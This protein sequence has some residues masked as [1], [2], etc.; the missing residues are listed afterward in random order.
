MITDRGARTFAAGLR[1]NSTLKELDIVNNHGIHTAGWRFIFAAFL[2]SMCRFEKIRLEYTAYEF[3]TV[4]LAN[5]LLQ[6]SATLKSLCLDGNSHDDYA[7]FFH[8]LT[9]PNSVL[10]E[11][12]LG[13]YFIDDAAIAGIAN[14][15]SDNSRLKALSLRQ[16]YSPQINPVR[17]LLAFS[18][19]LQN[20]TSALEML[21]LSGNT[22][23]DQTFVSFA[24]ALTSN[25]RLR[26]LVIGAG[27][28]T[29]YNAFKISGGYTAFCRLLC[30]KLS[31]MD[32]YQ[33]NHV[34]EKLI[35]LWDP[36]WDPHNSDE[37]MYLLKINKGNSESQ[38]ARLKIIET[39]FSGPVIYMQ[40]FIDMDLSTRPHAIAWMVR[41]K[42]GYQL[43]RAMP[44][45]LEKFE[46]GGN[47]M[48]RKRP[49]DG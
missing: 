36:W 43:L 45:L 34:L 30:N 37:L 18:N 12:T 47:V 39:H 14:A 23:S 1:R 28:L 44:S 33:S 29:W 48:S 46:G 5:V 49:L 7:N 3:D 2:D 16:P 6:N 35:Y 41:D 27:T 38:A 24:Q 13:T 26:K 25:K 17:G 8:F 20:P 21:D 10:E 11:L 40:P 42:H 32:T 15:L 22:I 31:I 19:V 4:L 9:D